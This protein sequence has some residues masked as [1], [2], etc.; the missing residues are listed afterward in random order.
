MESFAQVL[1]EKNRKLLDIIIE[2]QPN[3]ITEL[4][5]I[6]GRAK[7]NLSRTLNNMAC[8]G[9]VELIKNKSGT[10]TPHVSYGKINLDLSIGIHR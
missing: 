1:S 10:I 9:L 8:F 3:S 2:Q 5:H 4:E 7:S 6:L